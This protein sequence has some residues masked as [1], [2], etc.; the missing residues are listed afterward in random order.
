MTRYAIATQEDI[1]VINGNPFVVAGN[2]LIGP[3]AITSGEHEGKYPV[4]V[5][6]TDAAPRIGAL[7]AQANW[8][9]TPEHKPAVTDEEGNVIE[10]EVRSTQWRFADLDGAEHSG[11]V[12]YWDAE[13]FK[14]MTFVEEQRQ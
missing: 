9:V 5:R 3:P 14:Q 13:T 2:H 11:P 6:I 1:D 8:E 12:V 7:T 10:P 4:D